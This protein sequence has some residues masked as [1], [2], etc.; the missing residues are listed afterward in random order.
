M[1]MGTQIRLTC[2][3]LSTGRANPRQQ[4]RRQPP[5]YTKTNTFA[6]TGTPVLSVHSDNMMQ[7]RDHLETGRYP[8]HTY[9]QVEPCASV[10]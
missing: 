5:V 1:V 3:Q 9:D 2:G 4:V 7:Q 8:T 10:N 6:A